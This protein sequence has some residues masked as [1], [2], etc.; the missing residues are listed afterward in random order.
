M[1]PKYRK[2]ICQ[3]AGFTDLIYCRKPFYNIGLRVKNSIIEG[4]PFPFEQLYER[5]NSQVIYDVENRRVQLF[6]SISGS[7]LAAIKEDG[8]FVSWIN[9][10]GDQDPYLSRHSKYATPAI[11]VRSFGTIS[12]ICGKF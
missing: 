10:T 7:A 5:I 6:R 2:K 1:Y 12:K 8:T 3:K 4:T 11:A 9:P